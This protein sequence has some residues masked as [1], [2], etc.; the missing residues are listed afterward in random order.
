MP[1]EQWERADRDPAA[2]VLRV[3]FLPFLAIPVGCLVVPVVMAFHHRPGPWGYV[4]M[5]LAALVLLRLWTLLW[6][7]TRI[8]IYVGDAGVKV[9]TPRVTVIPWHEVEGVETRPL[10]AWSRGTVRG[11]VLWIVRRDGTAAWTLLSRRSPIALVSP[12]AFERT[13]DRLE[14]E[15]R[16]RSQ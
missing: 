16:S 13:V 8:G 7:L 3:F 1:S 9:I 12:G 15:L 4:I 2:I 6:R 10:H 11:D 5:P 14:R